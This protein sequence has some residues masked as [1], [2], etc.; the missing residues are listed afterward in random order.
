MGMKKKLNQLSVKEVANKISSG[1]TTSVKVVESCL[2]RISEREKEINAWAYIDP[3]LALENALKTDKKN[4]KG[5]LHGVPF[6]VK[7][8][9]DTC[10]MPTEMGSKIYKGRRP[11]ADAS[12]VALIKAAG[13]TIL[14]KTV[15]TEFAGS[16]PGSTRNPR[17][18]D[19]SPGGSSSGSA[20]AVA[21][22]MTPA[23]FGTQT[24]SSILRPSSYCGIIGYKPTFGTYNI[25][26][27]KAASQS[28]DTLGLHVR[29]LDDIQIITAVLVN[30]KYTEIKTLDF[31]PK[32][33]ICR[34]PIWNI[35]LEETRNSLEDSA[36]RL[37][38]AGAKIQDIITPDSFEGLEEA[39]I[40]INCYERSRH[41]IYEW[42]EFKHLLS[43]TFQEV[44]NTGINM[45]YSDYIKAIIQTEKCRQDLDKTFDEVDVLIAPCVDG[46]APIGIAYAGNPRLP[47]LWTAVRLPSINLPTHIGPNGLPVSIQVIGGYRAD[48]KLLS[49]SKWIIEKLGS[50]TLNEIG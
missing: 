35:T 19:H 44:I 5:L 40:K 43:E 27:I 33:G 12:C 4:P 1:E 10:D 15:T 41:M 46:E 8:I 29:S 38:E 47:G 18:K 11:T 30:R 36:S 26:G 2:E 24:G 7:D 17:N 49:I 16:F 31:A 50:P 21:D 6:G 34:T 9:I 3:K 37:S 25:A 42:T 32:I 39:R 23:A 13:A 14:G 22:F 20:A 45:N 48:D 28:L